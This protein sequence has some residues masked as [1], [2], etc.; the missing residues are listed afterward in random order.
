MAGKTRDLSY[1]ALMT[2]LLV[3]CAWLTYFF[4]IADTGDGTDGTDIDALT[5]EG[6]GGIGKRD[7]TGGSDFGGKSAAVTGQCAD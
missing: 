2:A 4:D 1:M 6:A 5:A 3:L 7:H